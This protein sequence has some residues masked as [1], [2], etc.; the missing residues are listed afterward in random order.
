MLARDIAFLAGVVNGR[1]PR[2]C[3]LLDIAGLSPKFQAVARCL[4]TALPDERQTIWDDFLAGRPRPGPVTEVALESGLA[5][6]EILEESARPAPADESATR[7][8]QK[9]LSAAPLTK[10][11]ETGRRVKL[12]CA[13]DLEPCLVDWLWSGRV[14]LGM[15]TMFAGDPKLGK[16]YVT[17]A[18][19]AALSQGLPLPF[20]DQPERPGSTI[21]M[22][23]EDDPARTIV[24]RLIAGGADLTKVHV[25]ES[26][27]LANGSET[28]PS[29]WADID[30]ITAAAARL[31][32][33]RLIV[34]DPVSAYLKGVD[35]NRNAA[36][37]GVLTPLNRLAEGLGAAVVLVNHLTKARS[38]NGKHRVLGSIA[39]VGACRANHLFV[40]DPHDPTGRRVL[41]LDNGG[42]VAPP[43]PALA[44]AIENRASG[45]RVEWSCEPVATPDDET[46]KPREVPVDQAQPPA[47]HRECDDWLREFLAAGH[48]S[49]IDVFT[50][51]SAAGFSKDRVRRAKY[52]IG[53]IATKDGHDRHARWCW[54]LAH[55]HPANSFVRRLHDQP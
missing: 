33:C 41:M 37:R 54:K 30:A 12:T 25:L 50:A 27:I 52:R 17:L 8:P 7:D 23:A 18:M 11:I 22:S 5:A 13:V 14:P 6:S 19:A 29:L 21:L 51:A 49:T 28:L 40:A 9:A 24:P 36:L 26:V 44:Y 4:L 16:S 38:T 2:E 53:A 20:S 47:E 45:P 1:E 10:R 42:N 3:G 55:V 32:D 43:A 31:G 46:L 35:D 39:Y 48:Q 34:I 15:I